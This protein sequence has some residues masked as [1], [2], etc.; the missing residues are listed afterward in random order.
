MNGN[1]VFGVFS[2][3][4]DDGRTP[5]MIGRVGPDGAAGDCETAVGVEFVL[6]FQPLEDAGGVALEADDDGDQRIL[7]DVLV[8]L[9]AK[10]GR[11][12]HQN[13][14]LHVEYVGGAPPQLSARWVGVCD[15]GRCPLA[16]S[17][18]A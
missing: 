11:Q 1:W 3:G 10:L 16:R 6:D 18:G 17:A 2:H 7:E 13:V 8:D 5:H 12:P 14:L 4:V 9:D 15:C